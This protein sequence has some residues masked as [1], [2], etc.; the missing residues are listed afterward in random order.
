MIIEV[1]ARQRWFLFV[2]V[3]K[4]LITVLVITLFAQNTSWG[5]GPSIV[6][7]T[8][9]LVLPFFKLAIGPLETQTTDIMLLRFIAQ[10]MTILMAAIAI[11]LV[12]G[13]ES[14]APFWGLVV[15]LIFSSLCFVVLVKYTER[16]EIE[17]SD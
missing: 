12:W 8:I 7:L 5:M 10:L 14:L 1:I 3:V 17:S 6:L 11:L 15:S 2:C 16:R 4:T 13:N 9:L